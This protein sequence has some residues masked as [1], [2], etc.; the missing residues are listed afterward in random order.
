MKPLNE[1][2][3]GV[4]DAVTWLHLQGTARF[5]HTKSGRKYRV[6]GFTVR[7]SDCEV[8]VTYR[9]VGYK[10]ISWSRPLVEFKKKFEAVPFV[11]D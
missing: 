4:Y 8:L 2:S 3:V 1:I 10:G 7:E 9:Q 11:S 6:L 5:I